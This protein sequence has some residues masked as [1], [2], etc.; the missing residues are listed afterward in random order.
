ML[1]DSI[2]RSKCLAVAATLRRTGT[3]VVPT[4]S[5]G[6]TGLPEL[7][8]DARILSRFRYVP[9]AY[10]AQMN[11]PALPEVQAVLMRK[12]VD[13]ARIL[14]EA[15]VEFLAGT[16]TPPAGTRQLPGFALHDEMSL[17]VAA[18][19]S[20]MEAIEAAT[21][22]PA[23]RFGKT[24]VGTIEAG[25]HADMVLLDQNPLTDIHHI[26]GIAAVMAA[27]RAFDRAALDKMLAEIERNAAEWKGQPTRRRGQ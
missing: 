8:N 10:H 3:A 20:P 5:N 9:P 2:D 14:H 17:L 25:M 23:R 11:G 18:G 24:D 1:A 15:G 7:R 13:F 27:G 19:L 26:R 6:R 16:D 21:R 12:R 4:L 22:K